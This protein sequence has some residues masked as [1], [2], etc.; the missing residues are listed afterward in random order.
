M[1]FFFSACLWDVNPSQAYKGFPGGSSGKEPACQCRRCKRQGSVPGKNGFPSKDPLEEGMAAHSS[2]LAWRIPWT[3]EP[4]SLRSIE[5][6]RVRHDWS[7]LA[8]T[9]AQAYNPGVLSAGTDSHP[10]ETQSSWQ[11]PLVSLSL[12]EGRSLTSINTSE[13][14]HASSLRPALVNFL[15]HFSSKPGTIKLS[16][17]YSQSLFPTAVHVCA[18]PLSRV[19]LFVTP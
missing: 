12:P 17:P 3:E 7:D 11:R 10:S 16:G 1:I 4:G 15:Q 8:P 13:Q 5:S 18:Q 14:T 9:H 19:P 6:Q 2:L